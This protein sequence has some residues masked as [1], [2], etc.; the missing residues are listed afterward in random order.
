MHSANYNFQGR[1]RDIKS[2]EAWSPRMGISSEFCLSVL[3][4]ASLSK[5]LYNMDKWQMVFDG[6]IFCNIVQNSK[7][8]HFTQKILTWK[9]ASSFLKTDLASKE[10]RY[11]SWLRNVSA[12]HFNVSSKTKQPPCSL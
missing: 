4:T 6:A 9:V 10:S 5:L 12:L 7:T 2:G 3:A 1:R 8:C 11:K